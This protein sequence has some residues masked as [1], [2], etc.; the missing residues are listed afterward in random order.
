PG[1]RDTEHDVQRHRNQYGIH[2]E[3]ERRERIRL[4][5]RRK[6]SAQAVFQALTDD[7]EQRQQQKQRKDQPGKADQNAPRHRA[8]TT[9]SI[10]GGSGNKRWTGHIGRISV[11]IGMLPA[12]KITEPYSPT[13][14]ANASAKPVSQA[15]SS[16]G[17]RII[18]RG[19][20]AQLEGGQHARCGHDVP[21]LGGAQLRGMNEHGRKRYQHNQ[22]EV[23]QGVAQRQPEAGRAAENLSENALSATAS[24]VGVSSYRFAAL[25]RDVDLVEDPAVVE[26]FRLSRFPAAEVFVDGQQVQFR[27]LLLILGSHF[28]VTWTVEVLRRNFLTFL[29]VQVLEVFGRDFG[30][31]ML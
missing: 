7:H 5:N 28:L 30:G 4:K 18:K 25:L 12:M 23:H 11:F 9:G 27:E 24:P 19:A 20:E 6:E 26:E 13:P 17:T 21:E 3:L 31:A 29:A 14:R 16:A 2:R 8:A 10:G 15:G 1:R 22:A